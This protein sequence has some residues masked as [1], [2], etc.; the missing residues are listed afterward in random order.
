MIH[1]AQRPGRLPSLDRDRSQ[2]RDEVVQLCGFRVGDEEYAL[3]IMR[4]KEIINPLPIRRVP[5]SPPFVEG[6]VELRGKVLPVIDMRKRFDV[7]PLTPEQAQDPAV[8]RARKYLIVPID[9]HII[10]LIVDRVSD[11][12]RVSRDAIRPTPELTQTE[13]ARYF[14]GVCHHRDRILMVLDLDAILSSSEKIS[15]AGFHRGGTGSEAGA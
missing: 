13:A 2:A 9:G 6:L 7:P 14:V 10:G 4:I 5:K 8:Q 1:W 15:L 3:D 11:V 12:I